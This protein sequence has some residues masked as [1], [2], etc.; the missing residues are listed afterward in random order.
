MLV[1]PYDFLC[2]LLCLSANTKITMEVIMET[3]PIGLIKKYRVC[4]SLNITIIANVN[5]NAIKTN[6]VISTV[7]SVF[8]AL[9]SLITT[10]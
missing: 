1:V 6:R 7:N 9:S 5:N 3:T 2:F 8:F 10:P 4:I